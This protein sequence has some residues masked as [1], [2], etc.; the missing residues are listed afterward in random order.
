MN[1]EYRKFGNRVHN[2]NYHIVYCPKFRKK[3]LVGDI[4]GRCELLMRQKCTELGCEVVALEIMPDH[5]HLFIA[6][7]PDFAPNHIIAQLK[8][9]T[10][11]MLRQE[12]PALKSRLPS[13]WTNAYFVATVGGAPLAVIK[14][15]IENQKNV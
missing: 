12:F 5:I 7:T 10:S 4:A 13:L 11:R 1:K 8:G 15:Y 6:A 3:C 14:Q 2:L 9:Y